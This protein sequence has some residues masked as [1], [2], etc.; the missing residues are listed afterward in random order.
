MMQDKPKPV[1]PDVIDD[2]VIRTLLQQASPTEPSMSTSRPSPQLTECDEDC[3]CKD[4]D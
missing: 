4:C 3:D 2:A 1:I